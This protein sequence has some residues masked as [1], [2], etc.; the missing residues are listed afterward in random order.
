MPDGGKLIV[1]C[2]EAQ[3]TDRVFCVPGESY[4]TVLNALYDSPIEAI[5]ARQEGGAAM[6]AEADGKATGRPGICLVTRGPGASNAMAGVHVAQQDSTPLILIVGQVAREF[7]GRDAFQEMD[8]EATFSAA[9]KLTVEITNASQIPKVMTQAFNTAMNGRPGPVVISV[10]EDMLAEQTNAQPCT[11]VVPEEIDPKKETIDEFN[12]LI[13]S[14]EA[15]VMIVGGSGWNSNSIDKVKQYALNNGI[16]VAASFRRQHLF[17]NLGAAY[18]GDLGIG[19]NPELIEL[20][21]KSDLIILL[22]GRLSEIPS[23]NFTLLEIPHPKQQLVHVHPGLE[24]LGRVYK[25]RLAINASPIAFLNTISS[26]KQTPQLSALREAHEVYLRWSSPMPSSNHQLNMSEA[27]HKLGEALPDDAIITN[28]AGNYASW[29]HRF[30]RFRTFQ[31]QFSPNSGSM[32]YGLP[33]AIAAKLRFPERK[34]ICFAGDGCLQMTIQELGTAKQYGVNIIVIVVDNGMYGTIRMHQ[35][36]N[37]PYR[38]SSTNLTNPDFALIAEAYGFFAGTAETN[39]QF[40]TLFQSALSADKP[41]L[42]HLKTNPE[43]I[44]PTMT[45]NAIRDRHSN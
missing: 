8:I 32:G 31:S 36:L 23:Q 24:E 13:N 29:I 7:Q 43:E 39:E 5:I 42:I 6:M 45:I 15:P 41:C 3:E 9:A 17:D 26:A 37:Y 18:A 4:L 40:H 27:I 14:A 16:P 22:G 20:I 2:L 21:R 34:V 30:Y 1:A 28:G 44:T 38:V 25:P 11:L 33:A 12:A 10:P 19:A 35:E